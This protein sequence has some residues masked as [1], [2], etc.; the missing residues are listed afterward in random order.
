LTQHSRRPA[1]SKRAAESAEGTHTDF[2]PL[3]EGALV[4]QDVFY[5][6]H[7]YGGDL[8]H[9]IYV[10]EEV[11][12]TLPCPNPACGQ[13]E[14]SVGQALC[15]AC[16]TPLDS[17][18]AVRRR[19]QLHEYREFAPVEVAAHIAA[20]ELRHTALLPQVYFSERP[21]GRQ[22]RHYL[23][24]PE[25]RP[26]LASQVPVPQKLVR[27]LNWGVQLAD[28]LA[29]LHENHIGWR[30]ITPAHIAL[31]ERSAMWSDFTAA[32]RLAADETEASFQ[33]MNDVVGLTRI[34]YYLATG[35]DTFTPDANLP[36]AASILFEHILGD[37]PPEMTAT[38][39]AQE[40][41]HAVEVI[42][43]PNTVRTRIGRC[44]DVGK[45]RDLNEDSLLTLELDRVRCS[46]SQAISLVAIADGM[47]GH[48][49]GDVASSLAIDALA[50]RMVTHLL[51]PHL[52]GNGK[53]EALQPCAWLENAVQ[54]ANQVV[55]AQ[56]QAA[57]TNMGTTL[58]AALVV[59]DTAYIANVGD[60]R[61]YLVNET[62]IQQITTDHSLVERLVALGHIDAEE[63]RTHPQRNV[64]YRTLGDQSEV[65]VDYFVQ[66]IESGDNLLLCSDGLTA[67]AEDEEI[68]NTVVCCRSPQ[69]ACERL[70]QLANSHGGQDNVTAVL[71][72]MQ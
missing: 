68:R 27:V 14:N 45:V 23:L 15:K 70:V 43:R 10:V 12:A 39:L 36:A 26:P 40:L 1:E 69:E 51:A 30:Q 24:L 13:T 25:P 48:A 44:T 21:Y 41:R 4:G 57:Q 3:P 19:Y 52:A 22:D 37:C 35:E 29:Y 67:K 5:I 71:L 49:A 53:P 2:E 59:G 54:S 33:R 7:V 8:D 28:G 62:G 17:V 55:Y 61:A 9:N 58:V 32:Y 72:Q 65:E 56:R 50:E 46:V 42:R 34:V 63:A 38:H 47:G 20:T 64:I 60:S 66:R 18:V 11:A 6:T 16:S 31:Q